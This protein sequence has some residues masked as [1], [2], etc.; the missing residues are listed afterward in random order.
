MPHW[1]T[2]IPLLGTGTWFLRSLLCSSRR[3]ADRQGRKP[4]LA[5][6]VKLFD[7][8]VRPFQHLTREGCPSLRH[9]SDPCAHF[10]TQHPFG[11][12]IMHLMNCDTTEKILLV[13]SKE[14]PSPLESC[15]WDLVDKKYQLLQL[16]QDLR[17]SKAIA[18]D[19]EHSARTS[20]LGLTCVLQI[21]TGAF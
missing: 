4:Q 16:I 12:E 6:R 21:S 8:S 9:P 3:H 13:L 11:S 2:L 14:L 18:L 10:D 7:N 17:C 5:F 1:A 20:Y 15:K 19:T